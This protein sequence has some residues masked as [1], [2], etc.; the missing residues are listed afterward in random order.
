[1]IVLLV[2]ALAY[3]DDITLSFCSRAVCGSFGSDPSS[4]KI[5]CIRF[6]LKPSGDCKY[7]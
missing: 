4:D 6:G 7:I 2:H 1:M 3:A 5:Q